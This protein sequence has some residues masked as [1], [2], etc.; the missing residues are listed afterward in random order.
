MKELVAGALSKPH[1]NRIVNQ[2]WVCCWKENRSVYG[3]KNRRETPHRVGELSLKNRLSLQRDE[4][5]TG[6]EPYACESEFMETR[7]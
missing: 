5:R 6:F 1:H 4:G 2:V 3:V 7:A